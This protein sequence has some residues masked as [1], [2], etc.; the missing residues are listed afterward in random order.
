MTDICKCENCFAESKKDLMGC[1]VLR[2]R[3]SD[4]PCPFFK[5]KTEFELQ[6]RLYGNGK[7]YLIEHG[8]RL[9]PE[10]IPGGEL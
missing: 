1:R 10:K 3:I 5:T 6:R 9:Y 2:T 7:E 8:A 4:K